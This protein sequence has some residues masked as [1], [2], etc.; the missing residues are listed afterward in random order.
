MVSA[1]EAYQEFMSLRHHFTKED[2][3]YFKYNGKTRIK[4]EGFE[5]RKDFFQFAKLSKH[6]DLQ[7][8]IL[9][10]IINEPKIWIYDLVSDDECKTVYF[11]WKRR[12]ESFSYSFKQEISMFPNE[13]YKD[14][15]KIE[16]IPLYI[17]GRISLETL[18]VLYML[19]NIYDI[20]FIDASDTL[21]L[22][23]IEFK[24]KKYKPF[25]ESNFLIDESKIL[26]IAFEKFGFPIKE[27]D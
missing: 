20:A 14:H 25:M 5:K 19:L 16:F 21:M 6:P 18:Y 11:N 23:E 4:S 10:N 12:K 1:I 15:M 17:K 22:N 9:A 3:D 7:N 27:G 13:M 26:H 2:Y 8:F 24:L